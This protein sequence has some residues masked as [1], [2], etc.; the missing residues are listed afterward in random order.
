MTKSRKL[1]CS[2]VAI[3]AAAFPSAV[4]AR[5]LPVKGEKSLG[6]TAGYASYNNSGYAGVYFQYTF[7][8]HVRIAPE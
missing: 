6:V 8:Q 7:A 5:N 4:S 1:I 2:I 3:L